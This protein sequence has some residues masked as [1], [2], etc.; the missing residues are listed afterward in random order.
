MKT[1]NSLDLGGL[2][3]RAIKMGLKSLH[4]IKDRHIPESWRPLGQDRQAMALVA[5]VLSLALI[6]VLICT[7]RLL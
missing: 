3:E 5:A 7:G 1:A 4:P 6:E 2:W